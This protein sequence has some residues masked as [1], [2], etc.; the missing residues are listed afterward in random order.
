MPGPRGALA[1]PAMASRVSGELGRGVP[2]EDIVGY[3]GLTAEQKEYLSLYL[4]HR[5]AAKVAQVMN[6]R[7]GVV[8][9]W[10]EGAF[11]EIVEAVQS[12]PRSLAVKLMEEVLPW[13]ARQLYELALQDENKSVKLQAIKHLHQVMG[14]APQDNGIPQGAFL[15]V[16]VN[17]YK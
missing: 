8:D 9:G 17:M 5:D 13:S 1:H 12:Q 16:Q 14:L 15:N 11:A 10:M 2:V 3:E 7:V 6:M 4:I